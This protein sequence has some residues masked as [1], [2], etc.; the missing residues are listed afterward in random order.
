MPK[1]KLGDKAPDFSLRDVQGRPFRLSEHL[2]GKKT[3]LVFYRGAWCPICN[4]YLVNLQSR[5]PQ[6]AENNT[7][8]IAASTDG[9]EE[10][11]SF[12]SRLNLSFPVLPGLTTE[13]IKAYDLFYNEQFRH[14]EPAIFILYPDGTIAYEVI[15]STSLGRPSVEDLLA[16]VSRI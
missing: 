5:V 3:M 14:N 1:L 6:F 8:I 15:M 7:Q 16:Y 13:I 2:G 12:H 11:L 9:P 10:A 4:L